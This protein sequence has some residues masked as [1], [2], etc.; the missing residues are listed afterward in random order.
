MFFSFP[1]SQALA[2]ALEIVTR[3]NEENR[4]FR[5]DQRKTWLSGSP[6]PAWRNDP[7]QQ[8]QEMIESLRKVEVSFAA[9]ISPASTYQGTSSDS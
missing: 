5:V 9:C 4:Q 2:L 1:G 7:S 3:L 8:N 6:P